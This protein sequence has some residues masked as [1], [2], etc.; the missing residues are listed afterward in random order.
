MLANS[1]TGGLLAK[2]E[3]L[4]KPNIEWIKKCA[5]TIAPITAVPAGTA[6]SQYFN[7]I[8]DFDEITNARSP[9]RK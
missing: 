8:N 1:G 9:F 2:N 4:M 3:L 5:T 7:I 6:A